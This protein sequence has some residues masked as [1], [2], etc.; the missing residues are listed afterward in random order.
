M[1]KNKNVLVDPLNRVGIAGKNQ[2]A[3]AIIKLDE[4]IARRSDKAVKLKTPAITM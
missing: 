3:E 4:G 2:L 1:S